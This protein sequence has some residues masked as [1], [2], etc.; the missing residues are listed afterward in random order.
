MLIN[1]PNDILTLIVGIVA[2]TTDRSRDKLPWLQNIMLG[3]TI[4]EPILVLS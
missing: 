4:V 2:S 3:Y 1:K